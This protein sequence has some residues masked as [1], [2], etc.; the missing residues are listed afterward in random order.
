MARAMTP[1]LDEGRAL[2]EQ[3]IDAQ[4]RGQ[5]DFLMEELLRVA[6]ARGMQ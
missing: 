6:R 3:R 4:V 1:E 2:F 5:T